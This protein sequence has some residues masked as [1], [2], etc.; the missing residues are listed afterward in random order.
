V[1]KTVWACGSQSLRTLLLDVDRG[2]VSANCFLGDE[3]TGAPPTRR[4]LV[5]VAEVS[6]YEDILAGYEMARNGPYDLVVVDTATEL[7]A[8]VVRHL[9]AQGRE[10]VPDQ[11]IW[12]IA[13]GMMEALTTSFREL[14][15][16]V[17][18]LAHQME[19]EDEVEKRLM[20]RPAFLGAFKTEYGKHFDVV[21]RYVARA[22]QTATPDGPKT[23]VV[24]AILT[25]PD[26]WSH[27]KDRFSALDMWEQPV[28]DGMLAKVRAKMEMIATTED[29]NG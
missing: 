6:S 25:Q 9:T 10:P 23:A 22:V 11:R 26:G 15:K 1:G 8:I 27:T 19:R 3:A 17:I 29:K 7:Q 4:D 20:Y 12:G 14:G 13:L 28:L 21:G 2:P 16:H 24:R 18:Y 5:T